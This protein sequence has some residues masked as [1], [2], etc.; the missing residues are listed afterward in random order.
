MTKV[1]KYEQVDER[2]CGCP[3]PGNS[4]TGWGSEQP[5]LLVCAH[6]RGMGLNDL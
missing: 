6:F 2:G 1:V 4:Q 5:H 3:V